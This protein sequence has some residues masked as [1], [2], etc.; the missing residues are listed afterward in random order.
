MILFLK[1]NEDYEKLWL[2]VSERIW[3]FMTEWLRTLH[4]YHMSN[5]IDVDTRTNTRLIA[6]MNLA[7]K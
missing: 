4:S 1:Q 3:A 2:K 5:T 6:G 7:R